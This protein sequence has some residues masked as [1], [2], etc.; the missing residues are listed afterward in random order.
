MTEQDLQTA[1][2]ALER[3]AREN[4]TSLK[5]VRA[6]IQLAILQGFTNPDPAIQAEW[7][8]IPREDD[9]PTPEEVIIHYAKKLK[10]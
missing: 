5:L 3:I 2:R 10:S 1:R 6:H 7:A 8:K 4:H 9:Y